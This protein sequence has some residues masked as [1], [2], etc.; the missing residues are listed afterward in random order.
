VR[1]TVR[2]HPIPYVCPYSRG[3]QWQTVP[4]RSRQQQ[5][6]NPRYYGGNSDASGYG[7]TQADTIS[8]EI[9]S[10]TM[11]VGML[12]LPRGTVG[13]IEASTTRRPPT[14][15]TRPAGSTTALA[16]FGAPMR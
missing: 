2:L 1:A 3:R 6:R 12:V 15:R 8:A 16:A 13:M 5:Q 10:A 14:P 7:Q 11:M 9:F 4:D